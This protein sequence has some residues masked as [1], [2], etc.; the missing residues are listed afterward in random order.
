MDELK[1]RIDQLSLVDRKEQREQIAVCPTCGQPLSPEEREA[2]VAELTAR[3][4]DM[5]DK[6]RAN[7][8]LLT[9]ADEMV[10][11]LET[12]ISDLAHL[13]EEHRE[14][15][16]TADQVLS[17]INQ[18]EIQKN[19]W[20]EKGEP[21]LLEISHSLEERTFA[22]DA[23][24]RLQEIDSELKAIGYD[25]AAHDET[26][27]LEAE[28]RKIDADTRALEKAKAALQPLEREIDGYQ[29]QIAK[30]EKE[31]VDQEEEHD[32][33]VADLEQAES[34]APDL[35]QAQRDLLDLQ[36]EE[37]RLRLEV[38]AA[39]QKVEVLDDLKNRRKDIEDKRQNLALKVG[40]HK[41]L[42]RAFSKDGVPAL[43][44]EQALP[45]IETKANEILDRLSAGTMSVRFLTQRELKTSDD[46]R[47][48]LDIQI[49][50]NAGIRDYEMYSGGEAFR[51]N[52]AIRLALSEV[53]AQRAGARLQTL[54]IDEGFGSQDAIGRQRLI[55]AINL[56]RPDFAK[57][58]VITHIEELK[59]VFPRR[60]EVEKTARGSAVRIV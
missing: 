7:R 58:L 39:Q 24:D 14:Q 38:G 51:V 33:A 15:I 10:A 35:Q 59:E 49:S 52:F 40:Q 17:K 46:L 2:L 3:G 1:N 48:T 4:K 29:K 36:E 28:G 22:R 19:D 13:D 44:I 21:R 9:V 53:L 30:L 27:R 6:Y 18:I 32:T 11:N 25:A 55:E 54:V 42:E 41:Q 12:Q 26:R 37:N 5:G 43:L 50:D 23:R 60:I 34:Q 47:E 56:V 8:K 57:I 45:Q 31:I 20:E 16:R